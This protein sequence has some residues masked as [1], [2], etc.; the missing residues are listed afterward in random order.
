LLPDPNADSC[1]AICSAET[2]IVGVSSAYTVDGWYLEESLSNLVY[3]VSGSITQTGPCSSGLADYGHDNGNQFNGY[4]YPHLYD[5]QNNFWRPLMEVKV[6]LSS[7]TVF[8]CEVYVSGGFLDNSSTGVFQTSIDNGSTWQDTISFS[9]S[10][11]IADEPFDI[12]TLDFIY[13]VVMTDAITGCQYYNPNESGQSV[14]YFILDD[15]FLSQFTGWTFNGTDL[16]DFRDNILPNLPNWMYDASVVES[17]DSLYV[18][19]SGVS[20]PNITVVDALSNPV[21]LD[22]VVLNSVI[23]CQTV[24]FT[25]VDPSDTYIELILI[26]SYADG[27]GTFNDVFTDPDFTSNLEAKLRGCGYGSLATVSISINGNDVTIGLANANGLA[28]GFRWLDSAMNT[29]DVTLT[30]C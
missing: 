4:E 21:D 7:G 28:T 18:V 13:R 26:G 20:I 29:G 16:L 25:V 24:T 23:P 6:T 12:G 27:G 17:G 22:W 11:G 14:I 15:P 1:P 19:F 10:S 3:M 8:R 5:T 30:N 2:P 9:A